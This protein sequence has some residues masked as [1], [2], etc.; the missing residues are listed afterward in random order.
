MQSSKKGD[1][2]PYKKIKTVREDFHDIVDALCNKY[3]GLSPFEVLNSDIEDVYELY[4]DVIIHDWKE[5]NP[6]QQPVWV[7]SKTATWH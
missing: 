2:S 1:A 6:Q 4:V 5:K 7:T 3:L